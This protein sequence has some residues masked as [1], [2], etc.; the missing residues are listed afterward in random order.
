MVPPRKWVL[1]IFLLLSDSRSLLYKESLLLHIEEVFFFF[2]ST[3]SRPLEVMVAPLYI[4]S[5][6]YFE[7][8]YF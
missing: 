6:F 5:S 4:K 3:S 7:S 2:L 8:L 1:A